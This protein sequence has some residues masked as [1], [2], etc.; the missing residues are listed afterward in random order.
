M[1]LRKLNGYAARRGA[2]RVRRSC[3]ALHEWIYA[4]LGACRRPGEE[5]QAEEIP[6]KSVTTYR[7]G[8]V[9]GARHISI[10]IFTASERARIHFNRNRLD[11]GTWAILQGGLIHYSTGTR[12]QGNGCSKLVGKSSSH[13]GFGSGPGGTSNTA[14][15]QVVYIQ[16][17]RVIYQVPVL[18]DLPRQTDRR[19]LTPWNTSKNTP[20]QILPQTQP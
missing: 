8:Q 3:A 4:F 13:L 6:W 10:R 12:R 7:P 15:L 17:P 20:H 18:P 11:I 19:L 16:Y 5:L 9:P 1:R 2:A 14:P